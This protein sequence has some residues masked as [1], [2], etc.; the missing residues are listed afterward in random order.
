M[1]GCTGKCSRL[2]DLLGGW[3][4]VARG[5]FCA[6]RILETT[7]GLRTAERGPTS[8]TAPPSS[9]SPHPV[10][11]SLSS[12]RTGAALLAAFRTLDGPLRDSQT[13]KRQVRDAPEARSGVV[14]GAGAVAKRRP[15]PI[16]GSACGGVHCSRL[17]RPFR[18]RRTGFLFVVLFDGVPVEPSRGAIGTQW[19]PI[20]QCGEGRARLAFPRPSII[21]N[22]LRW[23]STRC[24]EFQLSIFDF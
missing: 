21:V 24:A 11:D 8:G 19:P 10:G 12:T 16:G 14:A 5:A 18:A 13:S 4:R 7:L 9:V 6:G 15:V 20:P 22:R 17:T 3:H 1:A 2:C 23:S